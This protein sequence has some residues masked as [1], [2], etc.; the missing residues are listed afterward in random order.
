MT[1]VALDPR[2]LE[3]W[4]AN[5]RVLRA[6]QPLLCSRLEALS[7]ERGGLFEHTENK[8]EK[9][10]WVE[11]LT[12]TPF[13]QSDAFPPLPW[14]KKEHAKGSALF[15]Y[16]TGT[17][18][19]LHVLFRSLPP[20]IL[21][22]VVAE[23]SLELL[24]YTLRTTAVYRLLS[25]DC[26]VSFLS[27][28]SKEET[29]EAL[30][31][32]I[33]SPYDLSR[34]AL[35]CHP[36]E[37][38]LWPGDFAEIQSQTAS[39]LT[40]AL[41]ALG[42]SVE[43]TLLGLRQ[44]SLLSPWIALG[45]RLGALKNAYSGRPFVWVAS[46]PSLDKNFRLLKENRNRAV[47]VCADTAASKL[48]GEGIVP[49]IVVALERGNAVRDYTE[50]IYSRFPGE[51]RRILLAAQSVCVPEAV[52]KWPGPVVVVGKAE[53]SLDRWIVGEVLGGGLLVSGLSVAHM[54]VWLSAFLGAS[55]AALIGQD[56]AF[57]P[58]RVS[59][60][61]GTANRSAMALESGGGAARR[62]V[63]VPGALG[64]TVETHETWLVFLRMMESHIPTLGCRLFDCTEGGALIEGAAPLPLR[65]WMETHLAG[66][67][68]F[69]VS[70]AELAASLVPGAGEREARAG[71][72]V[73]R[74]DEGLRALERASAARDRA[75]QGSAPVGAP[76][77]SPARRRARA[78]KAP[79]DH[80]P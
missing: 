7:A 27:P 78:A 71:L 77:L 41:F 22:V 35:Y 30:D 52:G 75:P 50:K 18:P 17:V 34:L 58:G 33:N 36:G 39:W 32:G 15:V 65:K 56:F 20:G 64:G 66:V 6:V 79:G 23:P 13:F 51:A 68:P 67:E 73:S 43:D 44:M 57:A 54:G 40:S 29:K 8:D 47:I 63:Q 49:H 38:A 60:A 25:G 9:G 72:V 3:V 45:V 31:Y 4:E 62:V 24:A 19:W 11:G 61:E 70:P 26:R 1:R 21:S 59:H 14:R 5:L 28:A 55:C 10:V 12:R 53:L 76:A 2:S 69:G 42:N 16:G 80:H 74:A 48:L 37:T 46:G